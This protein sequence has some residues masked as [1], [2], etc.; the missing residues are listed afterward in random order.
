[1]VTKCCLIQKQN[2]VWLESHASSMLAHN[3]HTA[4]AFGAPESSQLPIGVQLTDA[5]KHG[6]SPVRTHLNIPSPTPFLPHTGKPPLPWRVWFVVFSA[7]LN[8]LEEDQGG[9]GRI[10]SETPSCLVCLAPGVISSW[11]GTQWSP[12]CSQPTSLNSL[13]ASLS[14]SPASSALL[15]LLR[16][17]RTNATE[18][19]NRTQRRHDWIWTTPSLTIISWSQT[20]IARWINL[21]LAVELHLLCLFLQ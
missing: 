15:A 14:V 1:M 3:A 4:A 19:S 2:I 12:R 18:V 8:L 9:C 13:R 17:H 6:V 16:T 11:P 21:P 7:Y 20:N 10:S 5:M